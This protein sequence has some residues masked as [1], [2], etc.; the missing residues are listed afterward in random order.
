VANSFYPISSYR[1]VMV[2]SGTQTED[3]EVVTSATIPTGIR[4]TWSIPLSSWQ[5]DS[6]VPQLETIGAYL[7]TLVDDHHVV[8]GTDSQD[9]DANN[10]LADFVDL[11]VAYDRSEQGLG[12]LYGTVSVPITSIV[13]FAAGG[14]AQGFGGGL[15]D[16]AVFVDDEY[17]RLAALAGA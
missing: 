1:S 17:A 14:A 4:F 16:P 2:T 10:L 11:T 9:F 15:G 12:P 13:V 8:G 6:G 3:V 5:V 7:E